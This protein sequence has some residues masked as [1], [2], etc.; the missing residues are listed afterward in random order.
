[1]SFVNRETFQ[2]LPKLRKSIYELAFSIGTG[3]P[4]SF[5]QDYL[6]WHELIHTSYF[7]VPHFRMLIGFAISTA[8]GFQVTEKFKQDRDFQLVS[9]GSRK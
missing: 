6:S 1:M 4:D 5:V 9:S 2:S 7:D 8:K 3:K